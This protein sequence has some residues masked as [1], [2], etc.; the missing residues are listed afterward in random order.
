MVDDILNRF[1]RKETFADCLYDIYREGRKKRFNPEYNHVSNL[2]VGNIEDYWN[3]EEDEDDIQYSASQMLIFERGDAFHD[4]IKQKLIKKYPGQILGRWKDYTGDRSYLTFDES[5]E[6]RELWLSS[7]EYHLQGHTDLIFMPEERVFQVADIKTVTKEAF[8]KLVKP[9]ELNK[10]QVISYS[11]LLPSTIV[12]LQHD[13]KSNPCLFSQHEMNYLTGDYKILNPVLIYVCS[14]K[15]K[16]NPFK[17]F[18][19][20]PSQEL[21]NNVLKSFE[22]NKLA[23]EEKFGR[24]E[25]VT[26]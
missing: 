22:A 15:M 24:K 5:S 12:K 19:V 10:K 17:C 9:Y 8:K 11:L 6:Y 16:G 20:V 23:F 14:E 3:T 25:N 18:E 2:I 1:S 4:L 26:N 7:D 21:Q 13:I